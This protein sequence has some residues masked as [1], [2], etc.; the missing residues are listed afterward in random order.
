MRRLI[1]NKHIMY[2]AKSKGRK[3][4]AFQTDDMEIGYDCAKRYYICVLTVLM[5]SFSDYYLCL[6]LS[7]SYVYAI[8]FFQ[9]LGKSREMRT[10]VGHNGRKGVELFLCNRYI[11]DK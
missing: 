3:Q 9:Q 11:S 1:E 7:Y 4:K 8:F 6:A 2:V 5:V 10:F